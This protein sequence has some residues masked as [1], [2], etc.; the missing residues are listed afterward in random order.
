M[1]PYYTVVQRLLAST[2]PDWQTVSRWYWNLSKPR[3]D[4][5]TPA[6][7]AKVDELVAGAD[8]RGRGA[9]LRTARCAH[10]LRKPLWGL[11]RQ[12]RPAGG[13]AADGGAEG[14]PGPDPYGAEEG[15]GSAATLLQ[16][17]DRRRRAESGRIHADGPDR[18][19]HA[20]PAAALPL[21]QELSS[22]QAGGRGAEDIPDRAG[23]RKHHAHQQQR[24]SRFERRARGRVDNDLRRHQRHGLPRLLRPPEARGPAALLRAADPR[25]RARRQSRGAADRAR[26]PARHRH[27]A[28]RQTLLQCRRL[29]ERQRRR[30]HPEPALAG[31]ILRH[32]QYAPA[33]NGSRSH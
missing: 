9:G 27:P 13:D 7:Q 25:Q 28:Q 8:H 1:P 24:R 26:Q 22:R 30:D 2:I 21:R 23:R 14:L 18:R 6:M 33:R 31:K 10:H 4:A 17:R 32:G 15:P 5:T 20:R 3:L 12:G 11:P 29:P 19:E 16:P